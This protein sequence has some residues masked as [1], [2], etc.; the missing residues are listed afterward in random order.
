MGNGV[1]MII[2]LRKTKMDNENYICPE[3]DLW[4]P[5][6]FRYKTDKSHSLRFYARSDDEAM[7]IQEQIR[8]SLIHTR[9]DAFISPDFKDEMIAKL[10]DCVEHYAQ[11]LD[12]PKGNY[13]RTTLNDFDELRKVK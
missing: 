2:E 10:Y 1:D 12:D 13:A 6:Y 9:N 4:K 5:Y 7:Q 11:V 3:G 8:S